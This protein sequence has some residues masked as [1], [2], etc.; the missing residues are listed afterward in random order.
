MASRLTLSTV[1]IKSP[2]DVGELPNAATASAE[3][4]AAPA[5]RSRPTR[6]RSPRASRSKSALEREDGGGDV[7]FYGSGRPVQTSIA[8]DA[9][10]SQLLEELA[11]AAH[12]TLNALAVASLQAG[13]PAQSDAARAAIVDERIRRAGVTAARIE[14]NLR[15]P[16]QLRTRIDELVA[17][18]HERLPRVSRADLVNAALRG[19]LPANAEQAA[20]LVCEYARRVERAA[21][22]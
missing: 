2:L 9:D 16:E 15:L 19:G 7:P 11:R 21:A 17:A 12:V 1:G 18:A 20:E 5:T 6:R 10:C 22:A 14:R 8:M 13:L 4:P 3:S